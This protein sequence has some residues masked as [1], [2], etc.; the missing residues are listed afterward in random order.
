MATYFQSSITCLCFLVSAH[1]TD[2]CLAFLLAKKSQDAKK[3]IQHAHFRAEK[4]MHN[5][6]R[7]SFVRQHS[8]VK[9]LCFCCHGIFCK[10]KRKINHWPHY[11]CLDFWCVEQCIQRHV[12]RL[13]CCSMYQESQQGHWRH[14]PENWWFQWWSWNCLAFVSDSTCRL[15]Q[16]RHLCQNGHESICLCCIQYRSSHW[17]LVS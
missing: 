5:A 7:C 14:C 4:N 15:S 1:E 3:S 12:R 10:K 16:W 6:T 13:S 8:L 11:L 17:L 2:T 9:P